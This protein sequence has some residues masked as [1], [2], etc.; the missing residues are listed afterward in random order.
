MQVWLVH[1]CII[2]RLCLWCLDMTQHLQGLCYRATTQAIVLPECS[3]EMK[4]CVL[5]VLCIVSVTAHPFQCQ[6]AQEPMTLSE[7]N[8]MHDMSWSLACCK[9]CLAWLCMFG[10][11]DLADQH[12]LNARNVQ[13]SKHCSCMKLASQPRPAL[14]S[15]LHA[16]GTCASGGTACVLTADLHLPACPADREQEW[17]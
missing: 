16:A 4:A 6:R 12:R 2:A 14:C 5:A 8:V 10:V 3:A 9:E 15:T 11:N 17:L 13:Q 7:V 1:N